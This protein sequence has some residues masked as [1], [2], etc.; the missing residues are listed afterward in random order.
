M[1]A[2]PLACY[3]YDKLSIK[4][5]KFLIQQ[6]K[7]MIPASVSLIIVELVIRNDKIVGLMAEGKGIAITKKIIKFVA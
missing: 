1:A 7:F 5:S 4:K 3:L 6:G 2:G